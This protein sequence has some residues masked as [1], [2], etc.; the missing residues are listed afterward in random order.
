MNATIRYLVIAATFVPLALPA[1]DLRSVTHRLP[2]EPQMPQ[3]EPRVRLSFAPTPDRTKM[4]RVVGSV[5]DAVLQVLGP[6]GY[7]GRTKI[8]ETLPQRP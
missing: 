5:A 1:D 3:R 8:D 2:G 6:P 4:D 7:H